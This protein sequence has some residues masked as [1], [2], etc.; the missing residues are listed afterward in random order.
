MAIHSKGSIRLATSSKSTADRLRQKP[1][2]AEDAK[3]I[4]YTATASS[5]IQRLGYAVSHGCLDFSLDL[6][7]QRQSQLPSSESVTQAM[8]RFNHRHLHCYH[9]DVYGHSAGNLWPDDGNSGI[10]E[11]LCTPMRYRINVHLSVCDLFTMGYG[12]RCSTGCEGQQKRQ[13]HLPAG[14]AVD[15]RG[16]F[17]TPIGLCLTSIRITFEDHD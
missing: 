9:A 6:D 3:T 4:R 17:P 16:S 2:L 1:P 5:G 8:D 11:G 7:H 10:R 15:H 12:S 14:V 13:H